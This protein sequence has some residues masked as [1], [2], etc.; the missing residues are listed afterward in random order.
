ME[1]KLAQYAEQRQ[2]E[3]AKGMT[4]E[5]RLTAFIEHTRRVTALFHAGQQ[6]R[7]A[8]KQCA[9]AAKP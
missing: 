2:I 9:V 1:S 6:L 5:Q 3:T 4:R 7:D 8:K